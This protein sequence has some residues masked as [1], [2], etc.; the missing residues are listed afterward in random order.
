MPSAISYT[1]TVPAG[2]T[3][4]S[5]QNTNAITASSGAAGG[6]VSV[7]ATNACGTGAAVSLAITINTPVPTFTA[8]VSGTACQSAN[9]TYTTQSGKTNYVW[10]IGGTAGVDYTITSGGSSTDNN[11]VVKWLTTGSKTVTVNYTSG[12]CQGIT[13]ASNTITVNANAIIMTQPSNPL[14][15]CSGAGT[16]NMSI[17]ASGSITSYQWQISTDGGTLWSDLSDIA[18]YSNTAT[19]MLTITNPLAGT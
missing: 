11:L 18:P 6:N 8:P 9:V 15:I 2:W 16:V 5:G 1:W 19:A 10:T 7:T 4:L 13:P 17:T 3:I 12:G 14:A